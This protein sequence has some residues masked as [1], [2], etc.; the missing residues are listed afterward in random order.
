[1]TAQLNPF[2]TPKQFGHI[3]RV[4]PGR[5]DLGLGPRTGGRGELQ[6]ALRKNLHQ[7]NGISSGP[8]SNWRALLTGDFDLPINGHARMGA[9][10]ELWSLGSSLFGAQLARKAAWPYAFA[11]F[12]API[13]D[14][15]WRSIG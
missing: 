8:W 7:G 11:P 15:R 12:R 9:K 4:I 13:T 6:R 5:I 1:M 10:V 3:G 14:A 2:Q